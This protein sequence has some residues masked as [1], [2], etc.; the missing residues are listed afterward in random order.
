MNWIKDKNGCK[1][2]LS[3]GYR[4]DER[5]R[6]ACWQRPPTLR[7]RAFHAASGPPSSANLFAN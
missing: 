7:A 4:G 3:P 2:T 5:V 1:L 6:L